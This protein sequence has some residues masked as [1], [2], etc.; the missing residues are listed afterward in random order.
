MNRSGRLVQLTAAVLALLLTGTF[1]VFASPASA[2]PAAPTAKASPLGSMT[3][4]VTGTFTD[5]AGAGTFTGTFVPSEFTA[6]GDRT[7][8]NG[9]LEGTLVSA[10][11]TSR[12]VSQNQTFEVNQ[13]NAIGCEV[14]DLVLGPLDL[15]L[16]GLVVHLDRVVLNITAVPGAGNLLGNLLCAIVG[17]LDGGGPLTQ[18]VGLLNQIL[19]LLRG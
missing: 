15:D 11:G 6:D 18:L 10:D 12:A 3:S 19:A 8:A 16:L 1:A 7:L 4:Q 14:L 9:L 17:I 2:A 13:V 5:A